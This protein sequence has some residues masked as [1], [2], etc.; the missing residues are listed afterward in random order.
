M[1]HNIKTIDL[2]SAME[3]SRRIYDGLE[4]DW[5]EGSDTTERGI[6]RPGYSEEETAAIKILANESSPLGGTPYQDKVGNVHILFKGADKSRAPLMIGSH[7][8][9]V[10][11]GGRY[12]GSAGL[13][14]GLAAI[15][16]LKNND[17]ELPQDVILSTFRAEESAW[18]RAG[19]ACI[20]S[21]LMVG[22]LGSNFLKEATM[23]GSGE[24]L[25]T[26]MQKIGIDSEALASALDAKDVLFPLGEIGAYIEAHIEQGPALLDAG[27][28]LGVV[29]DIRGNLR[30]PEG[31][32]FQG[33]AAHSGATPQNLRRDAAIAG[34]SFVSAWAQEMKI[35]GEK[36]DLVFTIPDIH[37]PHASPTSVSEI[38]FVQPEVRSTSLKELKKVGKRTEKLAKRAAKEW[39]VD[40][41]LHGE[42]IRLS[43]PAKLDRNLHDALLALSE[44]LGVDARSM[45]SGAGHDAGVLANAKVSA[46]MI[47][48]RHG[49]D[50][51]S[52]NPDEIL[53]INS[54]I[55]PFRMNSSFYKAVHLISAKIM[56][57]QEKKK[58]DIPFREALKKGGFVQDFKF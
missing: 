12:D 14:A 33:Q 49:R 51:I 26:Q 7:M 34:S 54:K 24:T 35:R 1:A 23:R 15:Q 56:T 42:A 27:V 25:Y 39:N 45:P 52:H 29:T 5:Q 16:A 57:P 37:V 47:F 31:I 40:F 44:E 50:G 43:E 22:D 18:W 19:T 6:Y 38:C 9:A 21:K 55:D 3:L 28:S 8:D 36:T 4:E 2:T 48:I 13:V 30:F 53:A 11:Q 10:P 58:G 46:G 17:L 41:D 20:G 32:V